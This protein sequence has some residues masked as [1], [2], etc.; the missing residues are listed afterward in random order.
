MYLETAAED[1]A[2]QTADSVLRGAQLWVWGEPDQQ[3]EKGGCKGLTGGLGG[4]CIHEMK[5]EHDQTFHHVVPATLTTD[6]KREREIRA[7]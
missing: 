4:T 7:L 1:P 2:A 5:A 6:T 3:G